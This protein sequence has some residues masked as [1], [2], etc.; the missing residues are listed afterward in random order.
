VTTFHWWAVHARAGKG[1]RRKLAASRL[2]YLGPPNQQRQRRNQDQRSV[3]RPAAAVVWCSIGSAALDSESSGGPRYAS[4]EAANL[5]PNAFPARACTA[6]QWNVVTAPSPMAKPRWRQSLATGPA[7]TTGAVGVSECAIMDAGGI[8][9]DNESRSAIGSR[10]AILV[11]EKAL[12]SF[13]VAVMGV[14]D[15]MTF[16]PLL[17]VSNSTGASYYRENSGIWTVAMAS[18][19]PRT[20]TTR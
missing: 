17:R 6:H 1:V 13:A 16:G 20:S 19:R 15:R 5:R 8:L 3:A 2:A 4:L 14:V 18:P 9:L 12:L 11:G 7:L 10:P